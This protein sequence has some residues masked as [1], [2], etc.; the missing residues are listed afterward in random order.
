MFSFTA[1]ARPKI[2]SKYNMFSV[3]KSNNACSTCGQN[4]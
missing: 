4:K 3:N 1:V 2:N